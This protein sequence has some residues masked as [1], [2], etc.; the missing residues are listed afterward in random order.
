[1]AIKKEYPV[2]LRCATCGCENHFEYNED[3]SYVRCTFCNRE[4][5]GGIEE[6][7]ELNSDAFE[8]AKKEF[9]R[10]IAKHFQDVFKKGLKGNKSIK[11]K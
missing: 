9:E 1:M 2:K 11:F 5:L 7:K 10:D 3:K 4:Y 6:L 8:N